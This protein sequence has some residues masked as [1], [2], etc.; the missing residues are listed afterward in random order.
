MG[1]A[2]EVKT[3]SYRM[4]LPGFPVTKAPKVWL[5]EPFRL[6]VDVEINT[7]TGRTGPGMDESDCRRVI[8]G[9]DIAIRSTTGS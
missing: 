2:G 7:P 5:A 1:Q 6:D 8:V 3:V 9:G 4:R